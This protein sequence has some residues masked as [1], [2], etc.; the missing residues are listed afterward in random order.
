MK[1]AALTHACQGCGRTTTT[2]SASDGCPAFGASSSSLKGR[3]L[4]DRI[5]SSLFHALPAGWCV[6]SLWA[7]VDASL[8]GR[9]REGEVAG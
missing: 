5:R 4:K 9:G 7:G 3:G 8:D 2:C 6:V 1:L